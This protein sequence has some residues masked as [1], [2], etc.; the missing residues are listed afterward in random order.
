MVPAGD[1]FLVYPGMDG[2]P[3]E[4]IRLKQF[5]E[6]MQDL[7]ALKLCE[8]LCGREAVFSVVDRCGPVRFDEYPKG[9]S[10]LL[11]LRQEVNKMIA[12]KTMG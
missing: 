2:R 11:E 4:T 1:T 6:A 3:V 10:Y 7:R 5:G 9:E 8:T 12:A